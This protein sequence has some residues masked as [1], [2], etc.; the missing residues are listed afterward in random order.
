[1]NH[2]LQFRQESGHTYLCVLHS[3]PPALEQT[4]YLGQRLPDILS[5]LASLLPI[6]INGKPDFHITFVKLQDKSTHRCLAAAQ[7]CASA[8][9]QCQQRCG[10]VSVP[11][12]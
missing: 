3:N 5:E 12:Y 7:G 6:H 9:E 2:L 10:T 8:A 11:Q 4:V 1:M